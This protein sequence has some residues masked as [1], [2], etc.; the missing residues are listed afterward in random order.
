MHIEV[1]MVTA[2]TLG[3]VVLV[4]VVVGLLSRVCRALCQKMAKCADGEDW[5]CRS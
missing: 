5:P 2:A 1:W 4:I 3:L